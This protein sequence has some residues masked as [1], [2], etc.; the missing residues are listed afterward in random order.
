MIHSFWT[1]P[2]ILAAAVTL[3][4]RAMA[5]LGP[6]A[7]TLSNPDFLSMRCCNACN[8]A[9]GEVSLRP[10]PVGAALPGRA[11]PRQQLPGGSK[12]MM[13]SVS[14]VETPAIATVCCNTIVGRL[15]A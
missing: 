13:P 14:W 3:A 5:S 15:M 6:V 1:L 12:A 10:W 2:S 7:P 11:A 8:T 4:V 9:L